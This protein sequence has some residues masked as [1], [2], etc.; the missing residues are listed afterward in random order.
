VVP[1]DW[2]LV[3]SVKQVDCLPKKRIKSVDGRRQQNAYLTIVVSPASTPEASSPN[4]ALSMQGQPVIQLT[5]HAY[6]KT[7]RGLKPWFFGFQAPHFTSSRNSS[8][9]VTKY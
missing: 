5:F 1:H 4:L 9:R 7:S 6:A 8:C 3:T 2:L